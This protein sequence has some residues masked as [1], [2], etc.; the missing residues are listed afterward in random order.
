MGKDKTTYNIIL[1]LRNLIKFWI[2]NIYWP[3]ILVTLLGTNANI[4][5]IR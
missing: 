1:L 2:W 5:P 3:E 4:Y